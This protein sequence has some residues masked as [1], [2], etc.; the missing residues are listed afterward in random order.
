VTGWTIETL[1]EHLSLLIAKQEQATVVA[2]A[3]AERASTAAMHAAKEAVTKAEAAAEKRFEG[4]NEFR[5]T[6]SDQA[7]H[8]ATRREVETQISALADKLDALD[9]RL[10]R[11]EGRREGYSAGWLFLIGLIAAIGT[12]LSILS[13]LPG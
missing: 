6:L 7:A 4:V 13:M 11:I 10:T 3:A 9:S 5:Q 1:H 2:L 12:L 8:F